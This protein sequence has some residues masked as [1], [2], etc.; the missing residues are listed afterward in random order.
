VR[1]NDL[2]QYDQLAG[3]WWRPG[4]VFELLRGIA[5]ARARLIPPPRRPGAV[6]VDL[7]CGGG[8]MAPHIPDGYVHLGVDRVASALASA[9]EHGVAPVR[10]DV[11][12]LP[13]RDGCADVVCAGELL[14]H[15]PDLPAA[16]A[17]ACRILRPGGLLV[18]DT[19]N[20]TRLARFL[21]VSVAERLAPSVAGIHDPQLFVDP[22][23]LRR[24]CA[25]HGVRL[26]LRGLRPELPALLRWLVT[27]NNPVPMVPTFSTA[28]LYQ[29]RGT[30]S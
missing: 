14:E 16:V 22:D 30:K 17:E 11:G 13:M 25:R 21:V 7:G 29:G 28:V 24:E 8:L 15:V 18:L 10:A 5:A 12:A 4:G 20:A 2:A 19:V 3:E 26:A 1:R 23:L 9:R 6:L 27:R